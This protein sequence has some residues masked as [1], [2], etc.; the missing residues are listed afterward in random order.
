M[1]ISAPVV[2]DLCTFCGHNRVAT[3][4]LRYCSD[5]ENLVYIA[6]ANLGVPHQTIL[7]KHAP[8][9]LRLQVGP[10][11]RIPCAR[12]QRR[13]LSRI[14]ARFNVTKWLRYTGARARR[15]ACGH[16]MWTLHVDT[17]NIAATCQSGTEHI[18]NVLPGSAGRKFRSRLLGRMAA[19]RRSGCSY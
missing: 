2:H 17:E 11:T 12:A 3:T 16:C 13:A 19:E 4:L 6:S 8:G 10:A 5:C 9:R 18:A 14:C 7:S 1:T 15:A